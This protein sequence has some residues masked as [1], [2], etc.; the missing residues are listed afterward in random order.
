M[1]DLIFI[2]V[3]GCLAG[4]FLGYISG[5]AV[6]VVSCI[7]LEN[8]DGLIL[9]QTPERLKEYSA[10]QHSTYYTFRIDNE[11]S[12]VKLLVEFE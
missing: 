9:C 6:R 11:D 3:A 5:K 2:L 7:T 12:D 4:Y 1:I 8:N 10:L